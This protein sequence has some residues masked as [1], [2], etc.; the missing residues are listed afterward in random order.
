MKSEFLEELKNIIKVWGESE[1][2]KSNIAETQEV[3]NKAKK[4]TSRG[5]K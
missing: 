1:M 4:K 2:I 3:D 5:R